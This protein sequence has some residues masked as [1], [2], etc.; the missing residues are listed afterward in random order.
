MKRILCVI[1]SLFCASQAHAITKYKGASDYENR[2][3][4]AIELFAAMTYVS[5]M[6]TEKLLP[7]GEDKMFRKR[8]KAYDLLEFK[9][10]CNTYFADKYDM[11]SPLREIQIKVASRGY[12]A[13]RDRVH[14]GTPPEVVEHDIESRA[15]DFWN[16]K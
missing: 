13:A 4:E 11:W 7:E 2:C 14:K 9:E 6:E 3:F 15:Q 1:S 12:A 5:Y 16:S 10:K 8:T